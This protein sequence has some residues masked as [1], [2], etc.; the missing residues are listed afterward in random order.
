[1][2]QILFLH[3]SLGLNKAEYWP[4][5]TVAFLLIPLTTKPTTNSYNTSFAVTNLFN[6]RVLLISLFI[7]FF[8]KNTT[9]YSK[10]IYFI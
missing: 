9:Q 1:M 5:K 2:T 4:N 8:H 7:Y 3:S 6:L 10:E